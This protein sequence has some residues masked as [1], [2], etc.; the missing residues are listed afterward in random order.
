MAKKKAEL[1][2]EEKLE[3]ALVPLE[4]QPYAV[5]ENWVWTRLGEVIKVSSGKNLTSKNMVS[6]GKIPVYGGNGITGYHSDFNQEGKTIVIGR[7]GFY[8]GS[9]HATNEKAWV[10]DNAFVTSYHEHTFEFFF[11]FNLLVYL[12][13]GEYSVSTAQPVISGKTIYPIPVPL[14][15]LAEQTRIVSRIESLFSKLDEAR[16]LIESSLNRFEERKS[17]ILH[18]AFS[19]ELTKQWREEN[20]VG[21]EWEE[22]RLELLSTKIGDGLHGTPAYD[23]SGKYYFVNG[24]NL[25]KTEIL[26]KND[27]KRI[28]DVEYNKIKKELNT[29]T[30]FLSINGT[31]GNT[32]FYNNEPIALGKS[33]CYINVSNR[34]SKFF[35]R[36]LFETNSFI[37]YA[38]TVATGST[39]KNLSL[40]SVR[41]LEIHLPTLPE[42][43]EIVR[44]LDDILG[45]ESEA[46][47]LLNLLEKIDLM[48]KA[49]LGRAFRGELGTNRGDEESAEGLL[50]EVIGGEK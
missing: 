27:T 46:K 38:N 39:I 36:Y 35:L 19:G 40:K 14:P 48:K 34:L 6:T 13:L 11:L 10:T 17:A 23:E 44:I 50:R 43:E 31:L 28:N 9:V 20:G 25:N 26:I 24:N 21:F 37:N 32:A 5:P 33:A 29:N 3:Q 4:E 22:T 8:C 47:E 1:T 18:K 12:K 16:E 42:Q 49:I 15:P 2:L 41:N 45:K 7:V 30:V